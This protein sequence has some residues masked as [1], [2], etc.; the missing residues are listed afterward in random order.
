MQPIVAIIGRP[1]VGKST[2]F[3][4]LTRTRDALVNDFPGLT[5]DR[6]YGRVQW[7]DREFSVVDTGGFTAGEAFADEIRAQIESA[8][9]DA[10][11]LVMLLDGKRGLSPFDHDIAAL[12]R[13]IGKPAFFLVNKIDG[14]ESEGLLSEFYELGIEQL[15]PVSAEHGYGV[16]DFLDELVAVFPPVRSIAESAPAESVIRLAVVGRPN[17]G[18]SSLVN[19]IL[20]EQR[21][22]V[23]ENPGTTRDAI[24]AFCRRRGRSYQLI[25]TAGIR[26]KGKV[27]HKIEKFSVIK[28]LRSLDR[29]DV[30]LVVI[31]AGEGVTD[32]DLTIAGYAY[33]RGCGCVLLLNKW[34]LVDARPEEVKV[35]TREVRRRA[36]FLGYAPVLTVSAF[37]GL[38]VQRIFPLVDEIHRQYIMKVGTG[39]LNRIVQEAVEKK[40]PPFHQSHRLK[41]FYATQVAT[42]PPT[43]VCF[44]NHPA[45]VHFSYRRYLTNQIREKTGLDKVP[46]RLNLR[47]SENRSRRGAA[48]RKKGKRQQ[49]DFVK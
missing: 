42:G 28:A 27:R 19:R 31:D 48:Q 7:N 37:T 33:E 40:A 41:F 13:K 47:R 18:K 5:R 14:A 38:R 25:D 44:V 22:L 21:V 49:H 36:G 23:G 2:L 15:F 3:N 26:R 29:C 16:A 24:D 4:R 9:R 45:A 39:Q 6:K 10:D 8:V 34:D 12:A 17:V 1:N 20:G 35:R 32:Q 11:I 43:F 46:I 30:A